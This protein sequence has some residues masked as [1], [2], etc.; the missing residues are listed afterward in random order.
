MLELA[1][2]FVALLCGVM[3]LAEGVR[4]LGVWLARRHK[5][6]VLRRWAR[7]QRRYGGRS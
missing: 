5:I 1:L 4:L 2:L 6:A 3:V 7:D